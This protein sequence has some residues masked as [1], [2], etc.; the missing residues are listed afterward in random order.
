LAFVLEALNRFLPPLLRGKVLIMPLGIGMFLGMGFALPIALGAL[1]RG[2]VDGYRPH[3]YAA[4]LLAAASVMGG[5]G[6]TGFAIAVLNALAL[7]SLIFPLLVSLILLSMLWAVAQ[8][9][10]HID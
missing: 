10:R 2:W 5:E 8:Y 7:Q 3:W 6:V 4:G 1:L 9:R